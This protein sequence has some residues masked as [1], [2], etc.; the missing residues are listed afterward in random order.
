MRRSITRDEA[1]R[2]VAGDDVDLSR[3]SDSVRK[4]VESHVR[5]AFGAVA[6]TPAGVADSQHW[7]G[8]WLVQAGETDPFAEPETESESE[9]E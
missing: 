7:V 1:D 8:L 6:G 3:F 2:L 5:R 9:S 4:N